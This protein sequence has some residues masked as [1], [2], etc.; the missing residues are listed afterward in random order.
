MDEKLT[1]SGTAK[2]KF[3]DFKLDPPTALLGSIRVRDETE[4]KLDLSFNKKE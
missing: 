3:S 1:V 2:L 4:I